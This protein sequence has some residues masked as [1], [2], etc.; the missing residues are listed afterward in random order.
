[1]KTQSI[2]LVAL[3]LAGYSFSS[4]QNLKIITNHIIPIAVGA[5]VSSLILAQIMA[6]TSYSM[7]INTISELGSQNYNYACVMR[8]G[9]IQFGHIGWCG[10]HPRFDI[11]AKTL[12][13]N[14]T[15]NRVWVGYCV[16]RNL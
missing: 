9:L 3:I 15:A 14:P 13:A 1:M 11:G 2:L 12:V 16:D 7:R 6:P 5:L 8:I 10:C 4:A